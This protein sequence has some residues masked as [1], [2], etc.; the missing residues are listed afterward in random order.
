MSVP[1]PKTVKPP[2][3]DILGEIVMVLPLGLMAAPLLKILTVTPV[4][5]GRKVL[6]LGSLALAAKVPPLK[7]METGRFAAAE[8]NRNWPTDNVPPFKLTCPV[9]AALPAIFPN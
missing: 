9:G 3:P 8:E 1:D 6:G 7:L 4:N 2:V 5:T